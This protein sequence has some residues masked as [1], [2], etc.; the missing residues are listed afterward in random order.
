M[1]RT[2]G[3]MSFVRWLDNLDALVKDTT[4]SV[5]RGMGS[6]TGLLPRKHVGACS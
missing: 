6:M 1:K 4:Y 5:N 2:V 3:Q